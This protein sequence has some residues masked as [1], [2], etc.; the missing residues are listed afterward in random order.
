MADTEPGTEGRGIGVVRATLLVL[1]LVVAIALAVLLYLGATW[2]TMHPVLGPTRAEGY[3][4]V[5][6]RDGERV[7]GKVEAMEG[8]DLL[9]RVESGELRRIQVDENNDLFEAD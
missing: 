1:A 5:T 3:L 7:F 6:L 4:Q 9:I 8:T 2:W